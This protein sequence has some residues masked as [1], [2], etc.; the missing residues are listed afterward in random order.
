MPIRIHF[1]NG[2]VVECDTGAELADVMRATST[3]NG[4]ADKQEQNNG[5][6]QAKPQTP[7]HLPQSDLATLIKK[8]T[9]NAKALLNY[10]YSAGEPIK[11]EDLQTASGIDHKKYGGLFGAVSKAARKL[12]ISIGTIYKKDVQFNGPRREV[13]Y[14]PGKALK[15]HGGNA[16][17]A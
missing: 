11:A 17:S 1:E 5:N 12:N 8:L 15:E 4:T 7:R 6:N 9:P 13:W 16:F 14:I 10:L 2:P 3:L